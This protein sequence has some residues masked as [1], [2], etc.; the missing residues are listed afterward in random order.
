[1][2]NDTNDDERQSLSIIRLLSRKTNI[3]LQARRYILTTA[4]SRPLQ[5]VLVVQTTRYALC[6]FSWCRHVTML[7]KHVVTTLFF[8]VDR[9][10]R[11]PSSNL[12]RPPRQMPSIGNFADIVCA[13]CG[14][15]V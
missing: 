5:L 2:K 4:I 6:G 1:M 15:R 3:Y 9:Q 7:P 13:D 10:N 8:G 12:P 11:L 14:Q